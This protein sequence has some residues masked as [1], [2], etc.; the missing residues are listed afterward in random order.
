[1]EYNQISQG[2]L[3]SR[4]GVIMGVGGGLYSSILTLSIVYDSV[5]SLII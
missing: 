1:M 4:E 5:L 2:E 3:M